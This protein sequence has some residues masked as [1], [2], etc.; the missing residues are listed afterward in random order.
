MGESSHFYLGTSLYHVASPN[1]RFVGNDKTILPTRFTVHS[2]YTFD[3]GVDNEITLSAQYMTQAK[4]NEIVLGAIYGRY[5]G[6]ENK[7]LAL[8]GGLFHRNK[9]A[10]YPYLGIKTNGL[11]LGVSYDITTSELNLAASRN[12]SFEISAIYRFEDR[13]Y[14]KK[15]I[16]WY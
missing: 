14:L 1:Y 12:N 10:V 6:S 5:L 7:G 2:G 4:A 3:A 8:F 15:A 13:S 9:D 16:P 11:Q